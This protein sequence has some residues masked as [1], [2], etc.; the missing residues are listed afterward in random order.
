MNQNKKSSART[1]GGAR[2]ET[3]QSNAGTGRLAGHIDPERVAARAYEIYESRHRT[4][5]HAEADWLQAEAEYAVRRA[6]DLAAARG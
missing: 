2:G 6:N 3:G 5:G 4:D 1:P